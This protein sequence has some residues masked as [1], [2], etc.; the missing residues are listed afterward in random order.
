MTSIL[1]EILAERVRQHGLWGDQS[2]LPDGTDPEFR[3]TANSARNLCGFMA[4][5]AALTF[6]HILAEEFWEALSETD[7]DKL[8]AELVQVA[9]VCVQWCEAIDQ[10]QG[11]PA[12]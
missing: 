1:D 9:A 3:A 4:E 5:R 12:C 6:R 10:R 2:H 7:P 11:D 8:R